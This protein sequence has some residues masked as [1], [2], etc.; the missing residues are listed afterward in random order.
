MT[1]AVIFAV[2]AFGATVATVFGSESCDGS[3]ITC[4]ACPNGGALNSLKGIP[5]VNR[6]FQSVSWDLGSFPDL[7]TCSDPNQPCEFGLRNA[8][9]LKEWSDP[10]HDPHVI[11]SYFDSVA[12]YGVFATIVLLATLIS[13]LFFCSCRVCCDCCCRGGTCGKR[14]P[15]RGSESSC[16]RCG[17]RPSTRK[18][19]TWE[20]FLARGFVWSFGV[21]SIIFLLLGHFNGNVGLT[22]SMNDT[23]DA[24]D[25]LV[26]VIRS[27]R[28]PMANFVGKSSGTIGNFLVEA[29]HTVLF[30]QYFGLTDVS[31]DFSVLYTI[32][33][34]RTPEPSK[35]SRI[36]SDVTDLADN[37]TPQLP[38][39]IS[40]STSSAN[41][42]Y[43]VGTNG[44]S[45]QQS[46][47]STYTHSTSLLAKATE[48]DSIEADATSK[49]QAVYNNTAGMPAIATGLNQISSHAVFS[50]AVL[51][52]LA[53][54]TNKVAQGQAAGAAGESIRAE[55]YNG[56]A[57][58]TTAISEVRSRH[59]VYPSQA[60]DSL[61]KR[62]SD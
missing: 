5:R 38:N 39:V 57:N 4:S 45:A 52:N 6:Y 9:I 61:P 59:P 62:I 50:Q 54:E 33:F 17:Y 24:P 37:T 15:T 20:K 26:E 46:Y 30:N 13:C 2:L 49:R 40:G 23:I 43:Q 51:S 56:L 10:P 36:D 27:V 55:V 21:I 58:L 35:L 12:M 25:E 48:V 3:E 53:T 1:K 41:D 60:A 19:A 31:H 14:F 42:V 7:I 44:T 8:D 29:N 34:E 28:E 18:Y 22:N 32:M 11:Y 16:C 47:S